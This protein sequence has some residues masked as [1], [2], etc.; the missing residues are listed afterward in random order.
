MKQAMK[1]M[2]LVSVVM[3]VYNGERYLKEALQ[4]VFSQ[5]YQNFEIIIVI[6]YGT[7]DHTFDIL[8]SFH[9]S[10]LRV[11]IN[12]TRLGVSPSLKLHYP[13][14]VHRTDLPNRYPQY[15][16]YRMGRGPYRPPIC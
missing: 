11:V 8:N 10:R 3:T 13:C 4:S 16:R 6:E 9:D 1:G 15:G 14:I 2:P 12:K 5:T 7:H